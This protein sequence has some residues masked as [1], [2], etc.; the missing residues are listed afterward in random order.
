MSRCAGKADLEMLDSIDEVLSCQ[1][2][3]GPS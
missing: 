2:G 3:I 1:E